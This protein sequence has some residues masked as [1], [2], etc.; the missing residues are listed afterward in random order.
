MNHTQAGFK[1]YR[2]PSCVSHDN[3]L[4]ETGRRGVKLRPLVGS[5]VLLYVV[6]PEVEQFNK[7]EYDVKAGRVDNLGVFCQQFMLAGMK[8]VK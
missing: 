3:R 8:E 1:K 4:G 6:S 5:T 7:A 2:R